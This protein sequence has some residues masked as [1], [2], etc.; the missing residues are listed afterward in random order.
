MMDSA[1]LYGHALICL[2]HFLWI[3]TLDVSS[4]LSLSTARQRRSWYMCSVLGGLQGFQ[5]ASLTLSDAALPW[6]LGC[7][8]TPGLPWNVAK[9]A[10]VQK[11]GPQEKG[12][13]ARWLW[14]PLWDKEQ[15]PGPWLRETRL[16]SFWCIPA[17][18][19]GPIRLF[20]LFC[21]LVLHPPAAF[22]D[23]VSQF[24]QGELR[25][26]SLQRWQAELHYPKSGLPQ[27][28]PGNSLYP[29]PAWTI[30]VSLVSMVICRA[31]SHGQPKR[32]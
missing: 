22:R 9:E 27:P 12:N 30:T 13:C 6:Q 11:E 32:L 17:G 8:R 1:S 5:P 23:L 10:G 15:S 29:S 24:Q 18:D 25:E 14:E 3:N 26:E 2:S 19:H 20:I 7:C 28:S 4:S 16:L 31:S 21:C